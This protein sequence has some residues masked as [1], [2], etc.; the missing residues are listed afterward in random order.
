MKVYALR[1]L[2]PE[3]H[4]MPTIGYH[5]SLVAA[6]TQAKT[7]L[8]RSAPYEIVSF[9]MKSRFT[10]EDIIDLLNGDSLSANID[11]KVPREFLEFVGK[12]FQSASLKRYRK[13]EKNK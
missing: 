4:Y 10:K 11:G 12:E 8:D 2:H 9:N 6:K 7:V 13:E 5:S 3:H 1:V